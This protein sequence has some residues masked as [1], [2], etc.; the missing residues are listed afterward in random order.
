MQI[1]AS[2]PAAGVSVITKTIIGLT[3]AAILTAGVIYFN[4]SKEENDVANKQ[5]PQPESVTIVPIQSNESLPVLNSNNKDLSAKEI[6]SNPPKDLL[7][8]EI[9][10]NTSTETTD[11]K[12]KAEVVVSDQINSE[13]NKT[14]SPSEV[15]K[16]ISSTNPNPIN[17]TTTADYSKL[18]S[19]IEKEPS[20]T[21]PPQ[22]SQPTNTPVTQQTL[23]YKP[24]PF[25]YNVITP[26]GDGSNDV[27]A[28]YA[29]GLDIINVE[30]FILDASSRRVGF[31]NNMSSYW[32]GK[33]L[34][35]N[36]LPNGT[37]R[38]I[39]SATGADGTNYKGQDFIIIKR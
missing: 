39:V 32:D 4:Q 33:D 11:Q 35:G 30:A 10:T 23:A 20:A 12:A 18:K 34:K 8:S 27:Y 3:T 16:E 7:K 37:Y 9:K 15:E 19:E 2:I 5:Q 1:P 13:G 21:Y 24:F 26:N 31:I 22:N 6:I 38:I 36:I 28:L 14:T 29:D 17:G 25:K